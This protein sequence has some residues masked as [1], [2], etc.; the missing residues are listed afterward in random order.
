MGERLHINRATSKNH[1]RTVLLAVRSTPVGIVMKCARRLQAILAV[2]PASLRA[3][4]AALL[5]P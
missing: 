2:W 4:P 5:R 1:Y 3:A